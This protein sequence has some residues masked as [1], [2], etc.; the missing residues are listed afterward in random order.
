MKALEVVK[1][2]L[3]MKGKTIMFIYTVNMIALS[4][5]SAGTS[6]P[7]DSS[8]AAMYGAALVAYVGSKGYEFHENMKAG[9]VNKAAQ[10]G[11]VDGN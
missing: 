4:W 5:Y 8:I 6:K 2:F 7:I 10:G 9:I 3:G 11:P 1:T